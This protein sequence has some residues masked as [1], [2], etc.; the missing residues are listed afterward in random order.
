MISIFLD[1]ETI[2][3]K[4]VC[5]L[6]VYCLLQKMI[7]LWQFHKCSISFFLGVRQIEYFRNGK[8]VSDSFQREEIR[9]IRKFEN[10]GTFNQIF[11]QR[12]EY[13]LCET[14]DYITYRTYITNKAKI[15]IEKINPFKINCSHSLFTPIPCLP[16]MIPYFR[17]SI[18]SLY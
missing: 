8:K 2:N 5:L 6:T 9:P 11:F 17:G 4:N 16:P 3:M 14:V 7:V 15:L 12:K 10:N 13:K 1:L 18:P